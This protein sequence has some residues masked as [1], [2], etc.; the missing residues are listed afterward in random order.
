MVITLNNRGAN[1]VPSRLKKILNQYAFVFNPS[2]ICFNNL[3]YLTVRIYNE[4]TKSIISKLYIWSESDEITEMDLSS[5]FKEKLNLN[6]VADI[7]LFIMNEAVWGTFNSGHTDKENNALILF[8][9]NEFTVNNYYSCEYKDRTRVEKNWAFYFYEDEIYA[10]YG[11]NGLK[12]LKASEIRENEIIFKS[13]YVNN[14]VNYGGYS[15]GT[16]LSLF[17]GNYIFIAHRKIVRKGKRLY[18]GRPFLFKPSVQ[19]EVVASKKYLIHSI[20]SLFGAKHK[21]NRF[22]ISCTYFSGIYTSNNKA[23]IS[24]GINDVS[25]KIIKINIS[26]LWR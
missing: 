7:K 17:K 14:D 25:W 16:P 19:P 12:V 4:D 21:F 18:L 3:N 13:H 2:Y 23:I 20:K 11:L 1:I 15:I 24:Y 6:K 5:F 10:L 8:K 9:F 26:R 22:L